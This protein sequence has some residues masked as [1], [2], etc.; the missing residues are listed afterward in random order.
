MGD[1]LVW[2]GVLFFFTGCSDQLDYRIGVVTQSITGRVLIKNDL[3]NAEPFIVVRKY[4][5]TFI[6]TS[7]GFI[8]RVSAEIIH[9]HNGTYTVEMAAEVDQVELMFLG[10]RLRP[11]SYRF[12]RTL[13]VSEYIY[14]ARLQPDSSWRDSYFILIKPGLTEYIVEQRFKMNKS[15][16]LFLGQWMDRT[17][18]EFEKATVDQ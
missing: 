9:P 2:G 12:R 1:L 14:D 15:D 8:H 4:N 5:K 11:V 16:Q 7:S 10:R 17:E 13:G 3:K 6:Q 18:D